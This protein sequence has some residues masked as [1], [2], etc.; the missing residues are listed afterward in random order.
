MRAPEHCT[1]DE[2][3]DALREY[4]RQR[5]AII[6]AARPYR[7]ELDQRIAR[8]HLAQKVAEAAPDTALLDTLDPVTRQDVAAR[9]EKWA[10]H[11]TPPDPLPVLEPVQPRR[12]RLFGG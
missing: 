3:E 8:D 7:A 9:A 1:D 5:L 11:R 10:S 6:D 4:T 12:R 2:L